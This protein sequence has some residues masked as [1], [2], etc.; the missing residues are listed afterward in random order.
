MQR[1]IK[2]DSEMDIVLRVTSYST[3]FVIERKCIVFT[4]IVLTGADP[5]GVDW[6]PNHPHFFA[7]ALSDLL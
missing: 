4:Q 6:V 5:G 3:F 1:P 2:S 7:W